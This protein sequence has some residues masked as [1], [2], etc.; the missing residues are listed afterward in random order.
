M[1]K[2]FVL[3]MALYVGG[4][5][6]A[7]EPIVDLLTLVKNGDV[8]YLSALLEENP[9]ILTLYPSSGEPYLEAAVMAGHL[10]MVTL[11]VSLLE[12]SERDPQLFVKA[13]R[14]E[15]VDMAAYLIEEGFSVNG[16]DQDGISPLMMSVYFDNATLF[17]LLLQGGADINAQDRFGMTPLMIAVNE[18]YPDYTEQLL[19]AGAS[20]EAR[21]REGRTVMDY[22]L[23]K[24][25][26]YFVELLEGYQ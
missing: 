1:K 24:D 4:S 6:S 20:V 8:F 11:L 25:D 19:Q 18:G 14:Q 9:D 26:S 21:D 22:A 5:L 7:Q 3:M 17:E 16:V 23:D 12:D 10:P 13:V 2:A 15:R